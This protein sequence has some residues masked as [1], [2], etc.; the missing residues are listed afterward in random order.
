MRDVAVRL[1]ALVLARGDGLVLA[2]STV[3][4]SG[5]STPRTTKTTN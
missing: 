1:G 3:D 2:H 4:D 5:D